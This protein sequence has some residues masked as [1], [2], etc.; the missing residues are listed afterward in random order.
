MSILPNFIRS[1]V[2]ASLFSFIAPILLVGGTLGGL[3][4]IGYIPGFEIVGQS[5]AEPIWQFLTIFGS[6]CPFRGML[7]I[8]MTCSL[9][10]SIFDTYAFYKYQTLRGN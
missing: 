4:L 7:V 10:G 6:G 9:V 1:L 8:G 2:L 5:G 3:S